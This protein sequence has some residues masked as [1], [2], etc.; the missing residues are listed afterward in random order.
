MFQ[1]R[2]ITDVVIAEVH[3]VNDTV[4][5][6][7]GNTPNKIVADVQPAQIFQRG[8]IGNI[9]NPIRERLS[10]ARLA[11]CSIPESFLILCP[12]GFTQRNRV[13]LPTV[14]QPSCCAIVQTQSFSWLSANGNSFT[15]CIHQYP[16]HSL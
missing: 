2:N 8:K 14:L 9:L 3:L 13:T 12:L 1:P 6:Q 15:G 10:A 11:R 4:R 7:F 16:G 5:L